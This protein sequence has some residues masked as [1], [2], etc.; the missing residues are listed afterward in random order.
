MK[1]V[2]PRSNSLGR[3]KLR[4]SSSIQQGDNGRDHT[5]Y[6]LRKSGEEPRDAAGEIA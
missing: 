6:K 4:L 1:A 2:F 5:A 3:Q